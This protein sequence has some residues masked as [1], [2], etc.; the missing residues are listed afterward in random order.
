VL[1]LFSL[2]F[3]CLRIQSPYPSLHP[4]HPSHPTTM[5]DYVSEAPPLEKIRSRGT[6]RAAQAPSSPAHISP[7]V[8]GSAYVAP[9]PPRPIVPP[10]PLQSLRSPNAE[11]APAAL[12]MPVSVRTERAYP[13]EYKQSGYISPPLVHEADYPLDTPSHG[14]PLSY[15]HTGGCADYGEHMHDFAMSRHPPHMRSAQ[16]ITAGAEDGS[17]AAANSPTLAAEQCHELTPTLLFSF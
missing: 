10:L 9:P 13:G 7:Q 16:T 11:S 5:Y 12:P 15:M 3:V 14:A 4:P 8:P 6:P 2:L 17:V 1:T